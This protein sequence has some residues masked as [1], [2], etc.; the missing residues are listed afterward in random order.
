VGLGTCD[1]Q[2]Q[3]YRCYLKEAA[4]V[5]V[6]V[7]VVV[8]VVGGGACVAAAGSVW[9][10]WRLGQAKSSQV[11]LPAGNK[12]PYLCRRCAFTKYNS[13]AGSLLVMGGAR[14]VCSAALLAAWDG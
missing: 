4:V 13:L 1:G 8:I 10:C 6:V 5:V 7:V 11:L 14:H 9:V 3:S 12:A 2:P